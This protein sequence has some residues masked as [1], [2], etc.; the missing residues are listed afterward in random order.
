MSD[1]FNENVLGSFNPN[2][3]WK[4]PPYIEEKLQKEDYHYNFCNGVQINSIAK[5]IGV[6]YDA[7]QDSIRGVK[8][9]PSDAIRL[10]AAFVGIKY[11]KLSRLL[12]YTNENRSRIVSECKKEGRPIPDKFKNR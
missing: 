5:H 11:S 12:S 4:K 9:M 1:E 6:Q 10:W 8:K 7:V 2:E 3:L